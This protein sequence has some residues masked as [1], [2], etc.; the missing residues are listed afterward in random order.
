MRLVAVAALILSAAGALGVAV[1]AQLLA[2]WRLRRHGSIV[3][4]GKIM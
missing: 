3:S 2:Q 4:N 1:M